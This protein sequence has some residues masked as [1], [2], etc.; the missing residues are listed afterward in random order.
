[1]SRYTS[2]CKAITLFEDI[3]TAFR[4]DQEDAEKYSEVIRDLQDVAKDVR[5][6]GEWHGDQDIIAGCLEFCAENECALCTYHNIKIGCSRTLK[7]DA[8]AAIRALGQ[9]KGAG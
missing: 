9:K 4:D 7:K 1:M 3:R 6:G 5:Y 2:L 8:A